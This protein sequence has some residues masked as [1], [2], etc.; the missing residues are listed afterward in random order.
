VRSAHAAAAERAAAAASAAAASA[1]A[2]RAEWG[3]GVQAFRAAAQG[4]GGRREWDLSRPDA[5]RLDG[6]AR[7]GDDDPRCGP[8]SMQRFEGEDLAVGPS[9]GGGGDWGGAERV[10]MGFL[11]AGQST[12]A[13]LSAAADR[14]RPSTAQAGARME[15][16]MRQARTW[17]DRQRAEAA[18]A[19]ATA[20]E[21]AAADA[22]ATLAQAEA[23]RGLADA[24]GAARRAAA[25]AIA[26]DNAALAAARAAAAAK[27]AAAEAAA[28]A[29]EAAATQ[30]SPWL[31]EDPALAASSLSPQRVSHHDAGAT[32]ALRVAVAR[33][34]PGL[35]NPRLQACP[36]TPLAPPWPPR[37]P[38]GAQGPL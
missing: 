25:V 22:G 37:C 20:A 35:C 17:W 18:A 36:P 28:A 31:R 13:T 11:N 26:S 27:A 3:R 12:Y 29:A 30:G 15:A 16:Q 7:A 33:L 34:H 19:A 2:A 1:A 14:A 32:G 6:P 9:R 10:V 21:A 38:P 8:A 5:L 23:R 4:R 24:A